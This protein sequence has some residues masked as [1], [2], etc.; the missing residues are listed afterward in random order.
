MSGRRASS[1]VAL[2]LPGAPSSARAGR[3]ATKVFVTAH[4]LADVDETAVLLASELVTNALDVAGGQVVRLGLRLVD[5]AVV[6]IAVWDPAPGPALVHESAEQLLAEHG[7]GLL[8]VRLLGRAWGVAPGR[9]GKT[10]WTEVVLQ[11]AE[12]EAGVCGTPAPDRA[13]VGV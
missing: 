2:W 6:R 4:G 1:Q 11:S 5:A 13:T 9:F 3:R 10:V 7:R 8:L 12:A